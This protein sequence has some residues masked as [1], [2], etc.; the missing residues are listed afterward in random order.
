[1]S[2][3]EDH[4][5]PEEIE[6]RFSSLYSVTPSPPRI[7]SPGYPENLSISSP[8][9][10]ENHLRTSSP[11]YHENI[12]ISSP[13]FPKNHLRI[14]SPGSHENL[15]ISSPG[16]PENLTLQN[17]SQ[18]PSPNCNLSRPTNTFYSP[19]HII[20]PS[21]DI[22]PRRRNS[23]NLGRSKASFRSSLPRSVSVPRPPSA[24]RRN[25]DTDSGIIGHSAKLEECVNLR[26]SPVVQNGKEYL[27]PVKDWLK[28]IKSWNA[29]EC[30]NILQAKVKFI[31][32]YN[33]THKTVEEEDEPVKF[34]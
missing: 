17:S 19:T 9:Y 11:G 18:T 20:N 3:K 2:E 4:P 23:T 5:K 25:N 30:T 12:R 22:Y 31:I 28:Q 10:P 29:A 26:I 7:S 6:E 33:A 13:R 16:Y 32:Q 24:S 1:M 21:N 14:S 34:E 8:G 15:R 27:G